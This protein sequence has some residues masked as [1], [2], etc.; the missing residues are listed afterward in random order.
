MSPHLC[1]KP[2]QPTPQCD[3]YR[4]IPFRRMD[5]N[6]LANATLAHH[7][8]LRPVGVHFEV[9]Q[10]AE[11]PVMN[12]KFAGLSPAPGP[13]ESAATISSGITVPPILVTFHFIDPPGPP[14]L[15]GTYTPTRLITGREPRRVHWRSHL[16]PSRPHRKRTQHQC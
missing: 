4:R 9:A 3:R 1:P 5:A 12:L 2:P 11:R 6:P 15:T 16:I 13:F 7:K 8:H 10:R 14:H